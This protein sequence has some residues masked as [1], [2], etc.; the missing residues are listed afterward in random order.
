MLLTPIPFISVG[1]A[2][3][4]LTLDARNRGPGEGGPY[5]QSEAN[6]AAGVLEGLLYFRT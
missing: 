4:E 5:F 3:E 1:N 2:Q 6:Y